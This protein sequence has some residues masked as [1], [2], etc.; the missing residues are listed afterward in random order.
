ME[1]IFA[2]D[3]PPEIFL[4]SGVSIYNGN[5]LLRPLLLGL[6]SR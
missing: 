4:L 6:A 3:R 1:K 5:L 2:V